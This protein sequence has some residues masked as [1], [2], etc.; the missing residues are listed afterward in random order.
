MNRIKLVKNQIVKKKKIVHKLVKIPHNVTLVTHGAVESTTYITAKTQYDYCK[1]VWLDD[2]M[3]F[4]VNKQNKGGDILTRGSYYPNIMMSKTVEGYSEGIFVK[5]EGETQIQL[6]SGAKND[7]CLEN[8]LK[9]ASSDAEKNNKDAI[10][11]VLSCQNIYEDVHHDH[12]TT[13]L[14]QGA[15]LR[16]QKKIVIGDKIFNTVDMIQPSAQR[17]ANE[18]GLGFHNWGR[19]VP[20]T[21]GY[22][23]SSIACTTMLICV[24]LLA[25]FVP[26]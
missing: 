22:T 5:C 2:L 20:Q 6:D 10:V 8:I 26:R 15:Y 25:A 24:T 18:K 17:R 3:K 13:A 7:T 16:T 21:G 19:I 12:L 1:N 14:A 9:I 23:A 11:F 4:G